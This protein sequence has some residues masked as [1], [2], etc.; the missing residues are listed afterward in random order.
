M[1]VSIINIENPALI[2]P[3]NQAPQADKEK[4]S[5]YFIESIFLKHVYD[6]DQPKYGD[7]IINVLLFLVHL[8]CYE[9]IESGF[10]IPYSH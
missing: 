4:R 9:I 3:L 2:G 8:F 1:I 7:E 10:E 5:V 6:S